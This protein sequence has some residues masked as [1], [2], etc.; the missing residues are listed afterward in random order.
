ML[1]FCGIAALAVTWFVFNPVYQGSVPGLSQAKRLTVKAIPTALAALFA[2]VAYFSGRGDTYS[3]LIFIAL[4]VC[5]A[6]DVL[7][8][9]KF[10]VG[11]VFFLMGHVLYITALGGYRSP[12]WWSVPVFVLAFIGLW[13]F[14]QRYRDKFPSRLMYLGVLIYCC[15]LGL[16]LG[17][18][19]PL[20]F[21]AF[22]RRSLLAALG[23][24]LFVLSD[25][26]TCHCIL[27]PAGKR[28]NFIS[29]GVYY[30]GQILL[31]MSAFL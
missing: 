16:L 3:L 4:C 2:A 20:P 11:G 25:M 21:L 1:I 6:A 12:T 24:A 14:L 28:F 8:G 5:T 9:V 22:S 29:L 10:I 7:L 13:V 30:T 23:A 19:V 26:G 15:A 27:T 17:F 31:G 18:S